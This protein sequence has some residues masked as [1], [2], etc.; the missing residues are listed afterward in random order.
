MSLP[1]YLFV[2]S[3]V[4]FFYQFK[5]YM[6]IKDI[7]TSKIRSVAMGVVEVFG[8]VKFKG[9]EYTKSPISGKKS[10][11]LRYQI[12]SSKKGD[13][14]YIFSLKQILGEDFK[15]S[16][17]FYL[18]DNTGLIKINPK[19]ADYVLQPTSV[20]YLEGQK[21]PNM[22]HINLAGQNID[23]EYFA[24]LKPKPL[25]KNN[26]FKDYFRTGLLYEYSLNEDDEV[27]VLGN[28][29]YDEESKSNIIN[30]KDFLVISNKKEGQL[31]KSIKSKMI[32]SII[33]AF[34]LLLIF[35]RSYILLFINL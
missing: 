15:C 22:E 32:I 18:D 25:P 8:K 23:S 5:R 24:K 27:Y 3:I 19:N 31:L 6:L 12:M 9:D 1:F 29:S 4:Y 34:V 11:Y 26:V 2:G 35:S 10:A 30:H 13:S 17:S 14:S 20:Y 7:P 28:A 21:I 16:T 33:L